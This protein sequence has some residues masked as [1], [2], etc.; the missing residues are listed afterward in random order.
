MC[1][2]LG[3]IQYVLYD[4]HQNEFEVDDDEEGVDEPIEL[5]VQHD[6]VDVQIQLGATYLLILLK[7]DK[8]DKYKDYIGK[9]IEATEEYFILDNDYPDIKPLKVNLNE[10]QTAFVLDDGTEIIEFTCIRE[11]ELEKILDED[12]IF[13]EETIE[14]D[15][16]EITLK[17]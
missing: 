13:K 9:I 6:M 12:D 11:V 8:S 4:K 10:D 7:S 3:L 17:D 14:L 2:P 15:I 5:D 1:I 16:L